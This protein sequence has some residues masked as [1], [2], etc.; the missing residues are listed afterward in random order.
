ML[1]LFIVYTAEYTAISGIAP[2]LLFPLD[3]TPFGALRDFYPAYNAIYQVGVFIS[4][5]SILFFRLKN[6]YTPSILQSVNAAVLLAHAFLYFLP[7]VWIVFAIY[8]WTG[9][10][11]GAVY[12][13]SYAKITDEVPEEDREFSLGTVSVA[14]TL[15]ILLASFVSMPLEPAICA[16]QVRQGRDWCKQI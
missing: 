14:D 10:L 6:I 11:G 16:A 4:R 12:V 15:G 1:P 7:S 5:S 3:E 2:T 13:N 9:L 8:F